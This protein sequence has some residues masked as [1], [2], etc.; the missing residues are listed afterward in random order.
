MTKKRL[1]RTSPAPGLCNVHGLDFAVVGS[2]LLQRGESQ[3]LVAIPCR[4][5]F[6]NGGTQA[7]RIQS[8]RAAGFGLGGC[9][10]DMVLK[11]LRCGWIVEIAF[12]DPH[13]TV[14][15][16]RSGGCRRAVGRSCPP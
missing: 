4:P 5:E 12:D 6:D 16:F 9:R 11:E 1:P 8:M 10:G 3:E 13:P 2:E 14:P 15:A 7:V